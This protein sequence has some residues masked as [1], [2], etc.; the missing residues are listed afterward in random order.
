[1]DFSRFLGLEMVWTIV[2]HKNFGDLFRPVYSGSEGKK[3]AEPKKA[4]KGPMGG[5]RP[6]ETTSLSAHVMK[7]VC[8][9]SLL[10]M[11]DMTSPS[12]KRRL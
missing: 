9:A 5:R 12:F 4:P 10:C 6:E 11:C 7:S 3:G 2:V 1:M 8:T